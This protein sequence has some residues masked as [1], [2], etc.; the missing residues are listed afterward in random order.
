[1]R[2]H[3]DDWNR[4]NEGSG[5]FIDVEVVPRVDETISIQRALIPDTFF[6]DWLE[7]LDDPEDSLP[8]FT[9]SGL[10]HVITGEGHLVRISIKPIEWD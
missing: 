2:I 9:V 3:V 8:T 1:M 7:Y 4:A 5:F 10:Q 6:V